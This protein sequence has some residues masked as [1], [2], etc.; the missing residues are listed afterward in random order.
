M[1][2]IRLLKRIFIILIV[3]SLGVSL[4]FTGGVFAKYI[5]NIKD[6]TPPV[7]AKK[8]FFE[9][10]YLVEGNFTYK[11]NSGTKSLAI[12]LY[13]YENDIRVSEVECK[14]TV[15]VTSEDTTYTI[16]RTEITVAANT[17]SNTVINLGNLK[18]GYT[19]TVTVT[20][21]GGYVKTLSAKFQVG[22][23]ND[24]FFMN[25]DDSN[26]SYV[27]LTVWTENITGTVNITFPKGLIPDVTDPVLAG[28]TNYSKG[29][30]TSGSF[31]DSSS[32][33]SGY[34]SRSYRFFKTS[35]YNKEAFTVKIG[36]RTAEPSTIK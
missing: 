7:S 29:T 35:D 26:D 34:S 15:I 19:Y 30:Y 4:L 9:S 31:A 20:A 21:N 24:G 3:V 28:I 27:I 6:N 17:K 12:E 2:K 18:D 11:L 32:F 14:Y 23:T 10:N 16:D 5:Q 33:V 36:D 1:K 22:T 25:V 13:N 8:F